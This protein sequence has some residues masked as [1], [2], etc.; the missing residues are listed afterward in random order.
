MHSNTFVSTR[1]GNLLKSFKT[2]GNAGNCCVLASTAIYI[3]DDCCDYGGR[4]GFFVFF[5]VGVGATVGGW[6]LLWL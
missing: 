1:H 4:S 5:N 6:A 2:M 3:Y